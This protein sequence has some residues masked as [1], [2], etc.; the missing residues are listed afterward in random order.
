MSKGRTKQAS[1]EL[2]RWMLIIICLVIFCGSAAYLLL[3]GEDKVSAEK[4][5][6]QIRENS[7]DLSGLFVKNSDLIGWVRV[8]G[9]RI[10]Y[11]VMQTPDEPEYYLHR[12]FNKEYSESG[13]P[14]MDADS[15]IGVT[16]NRIIYGHNM[17]F[18]TMFHDLQK[19]DS[20]GFWENHKTFSFEV[21]EPKNRN[22]NHELY[23]IFAVCRSKIRT[24]D[25]DAFKY[26]QYADCEDQGTFSEYVAGVRKESVYETDI[27]PQ[28]GEQLV[29][30]STCAYHAS[31]GRFY[32]V[33]RQIE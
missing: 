22:T 32:V 23:E 30:L 18:G 2:C 10:D 24:E 3:Y 16:W 6:R 12:D 14:F 20:K 27:I 5:F 13:T 19:Y 7:W 11:P 26:Y 25:S 1:S 29:T 15:A 33:G 28:Y 21:Y 9:T 4:E 31:E 17:K 8:D